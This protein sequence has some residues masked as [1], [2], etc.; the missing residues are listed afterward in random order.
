MKDFYEAYYSR[1]GHSQAHHLFCERAFGKDLAQHGFADL[2]QL[3]LLIKLTGLGPDTNALD[4]GCGN[5][6]ISEYLADRTGAHITGID[7]IPLAIKDAQ[8]RTAAKSGR[9]KFMVGDINQLELSPRTFDLVMLIDSLYFSEDYAATIRTLKTALRPNGKMAIFFSYGREPHVAP[10]EFPKQC[11]PPD[12]TPLADALRRNVLPF[13][14]RD[15]T[16]LDYRNAQKR[17]QL[18]SLLKPLFEQ[19]DAL[20][21]YDN[22]LGEAKCI[23]KSIEDGLHKRYLYVVTTA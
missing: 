13:E 7:Y 15:L 12:K 2:E 5:G 23:I 16:A 4:V 1:V 21:I 14:T 3:E 8:L 22:R 18:L 11:L 20:F 6:M 17:Q 9:M 19:E 10:A